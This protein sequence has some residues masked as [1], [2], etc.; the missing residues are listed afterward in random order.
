[1]STYRRPIKSL[2]LVCAVLIAGFAAL[3][4]T[5]AS[6]AS[7]Q[8][9][10]VQ[11]PVSSGPCFDPGALASFTMQGSLTGCWY[12]DTINQKYQPTS[13]TFQDTGTEHFAGCLDLDGDQ[14]CTAADPQGTLYFSF[15]FTGKVDPVTLAEIHGRC[16]H[17]I[18][19]GTGGFAGA[20]GVLTFKDDVT[21]GTSLYRGPVTP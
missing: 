6:A 18:V 20:R 1:M 15:Q 13:G 9:S 19:A 12:I 10:G 5:P 4:A 21:N 2:L 7:V 11:T 17:P 14:A 16:Q 8:V 3:S